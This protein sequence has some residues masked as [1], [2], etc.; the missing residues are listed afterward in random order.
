[1]RS[2]LRPLAPLF[3][4]L[5]AACKPIETRHVLRPDDLRPRR[6]LALRWIGTGAGDALWISTADDREPNGRFEGLHAVVDPG[7]PDEVEG[8]LLPAMRSAGFTDGASLAYVV[9]TTDDPH[10]RAG[11]RRLG[12][13]VPV[14]RTI[15]PGL[16]GAGRSS[17]RRRRARTDDFG[18]PLPGYLDLGGE[19]TVRL[20]PSARADRRLLLLRFIDFRLL[21]VPAQ[22]ASGLTAAD[23]ERI[24]QEAAPLTLLDLRDRDADALSRHLHP[25]VALGGRPAA[26]AIAAAPPGDGP[27]LLTR[28][29]PGETREVTTAGGETRLPGPYL[30]S[31][32]GHWLDCRVGQERCA[33]ELPVDP[34]GPLIVPVT[35]GGRASRLLVDSRAPFSFLSTSS[36]KA[37]GLDAA[38]AHGHSHGAE[39]MGIRLPDVELG[40][41]PSAPRL[42]GWRVL[43]IAPFEIDGR[44]V[45][46]VIGIDLL[47]SFRVTLRPNASRLT[48]QPNFDP[49]HDRL[50]PSAERSGDG[51]DVPLDRSPGGP[52]LLATVDGRGRSLTLGLGAAESTLYLRTEE[53]ER[54]AGESRPFV[55]RALRV[56]D[57]LRDAAWRSA[58]I[59]GRRHSVGDLNLFG[60]HFAGIPFV[61]VDD[62]LVGDVVGLDFLRRFSR[63]EIDFRRR[64]LALVP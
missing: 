22:A 28:P 47:Q 48:L 8:R 62:P 27:L 4:F 42:V 39:G 58:E 23:V 50:R 52:L 10:Q 13:L 40:S 37:L 2:P 43:P 11:A 44:P 41:D 5:A 12:E 26:G 19:L 21:L 56:P 3:L 33:A 14:E 49:P 1:M 25:E 30:R 59:R 7:P 32:F 36:L 63:I 20:L 61:A 18:G 57:D 31:R 6:D 51:W 24:E 53:W 60:A 55:H 64:S 35:I 38:D 54:L 45:D 34:G 16:A 15:V 29:L 9:V 46:G 17:D